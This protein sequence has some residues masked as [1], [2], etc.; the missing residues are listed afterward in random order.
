MNYKQYQDYLDL[1]QEFTS[2][3]RIVLK[4]VLDDRIEESQLLLTLFRDYAS[5][6]EAEIAN[7]LLG[8]IP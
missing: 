4:W 5:E 7:K 3:C 6:R 8:L 2:V 1:D